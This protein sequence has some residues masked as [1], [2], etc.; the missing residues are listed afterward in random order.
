MSF[1]RY[2]YANNNPHK[3]TDPDGKFIWHVVGAIAGAGINAIAQGVTKGFDNIDYSQVAVAGA[4][5]AVGVGF[6]NSVA[7]SVAEVGLVG[8]SAIAANIAGNTVAGAGLGAIGNL[9]NTGIDGVQGD[10]SGQ[11]SFS[12]LA[13]SAKD[14]A[15]FGAIGSAAGEGV[16]KSVVGAGN[17][18][19]GDKG[20]INGLGKLA[21]ESAADALGNAADAKNAILKKDKNE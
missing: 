1:N 20:T 14:G 8:G 18:I 16:T 6:A 15:I 5:G 10:S 11:I 7:A 17:A 12:G 4:L 3:Y 9:A 2:L 21:A 13:D 19:F